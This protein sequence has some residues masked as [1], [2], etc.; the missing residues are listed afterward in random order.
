MSDKQ[1]VTESRPQSASDRGQTPIDFAVGASVFLL[2]LAFVIAFV[3][4]LF[5][6]FS[7]AETASPVV[8]DRVAAGVAGDLL[9]AS[10]AEPGVLSPTCTVAFFSANA[11]LGTEA[12]CHPD[13]AATPADHFG[14][15][16]DVQVIVHRLS[17]TNPSE[18]P[19]NVSIVTAEGSFDVELIRPTEGP[20]GTA[21]D[22]VTV[23]QRLVSIDGDQF[24]LTVRVW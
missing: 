17:E 11:T 18:N 24:R 16:G 12:D 9:A 22:D 8:S 5:D 15:D 20:S 2:T 1:R 13:V 23:S 7:A 19:A 21:A 14:L 4:T 10:P 3:P 6:P